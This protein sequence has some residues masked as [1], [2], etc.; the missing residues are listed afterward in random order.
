[1]DDMNVKDKNYDVWENLS[2]SNDFLFGKV[3]HHSSPS[4][5]EKNWKSFSFTTRHNYYL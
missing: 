1:M 2:I 4:Q 5:K 3:M